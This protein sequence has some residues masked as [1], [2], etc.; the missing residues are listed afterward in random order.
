VDVAG[1]HGAAVKRTGF[2]VN[3]DVQFHAEVP[4]VALFGGAHF[5]VASVVGIFG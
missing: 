4:L 1:G 5:G 2:A 3:T